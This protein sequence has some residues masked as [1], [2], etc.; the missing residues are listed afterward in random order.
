MLVF[1]KSSDFARRLFGIERMCQTMQTMQYRQ[2]LIFWGWQD[3]RI[4][5]FFRVFVSS[6]NHVSIY[7]YYWYV[8]EIIVNVWAA[9]KNTACL[10]HLIHDLVFEV[11]IAYDLA[12]ELEFIEDRV[13]RAV[14][15]A[16][17][18]DAPLDWNTWKCEEVG[19]YHH[20]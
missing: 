8:S 2:Q 19:N 9:K 16:G 11:S 3:G 14:E 6:E 12:E 15:Q 17:C 5:S 10:D 18:V 1:T 4:D 13:H 7:F 20:T